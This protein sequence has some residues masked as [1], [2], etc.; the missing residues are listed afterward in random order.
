MSRTPKPWYY[1]QVGA[2]YAWIDGKKVQLLKASRTKKNLRLA[3]DALKERMQ[4]REFQAR[5]NVPPS[6]S[7]QTVASVIDA[8]QE[9][10]K[11][12]LGLA[13]RQIRFAYQQSFAEAHGWRNI[14]ECRPSHMRQ[15]LHEHPGWKSD[16]TKNRA[17][18]DVQVAFNWAAGEERMIREN[19][20]KSVTHPTG[21][22]RRD[23]SREEFQAVLRATTGKVRWK[24]PTPGAR[25]RQ[26]LVMLWY[27][28]M[29]PCEVAKLTWSQVD[30]KVGKIVLKEHKTKRTQ[31]KPRPRE[32]YLHPVVV[33]LLRWMQSRGEGERVFLTHRKTPW[34]K[35]TLGQ[36]LK[37][38]REEAGLSN[39]V[40]LYGV[41]HSFGTRG[42][43]NNVPLKVLSQL[44]GHTSTRT[45]EGYLHLSGKDQHLAAA[46]LAVGGLR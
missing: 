35:D 7:D 6:N 44:M 21:D 39:D 45:T 24:K 37:R 12:S 20:F 18:R 4:E 15:W 41:R 16:W 17:L 40:K 8:Y 36:R 11:T 5:F 25:F 29:R 3:Q 9:A 1:D 42:V 30:F 26:V 10:A 28:G 13:T 27:T 14:S 23:M 38:A 32:V 33:K 2:Y 34:D 22:P 31:K 46:T 19:P 43:L